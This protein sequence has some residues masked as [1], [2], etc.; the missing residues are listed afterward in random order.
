[1]R[2]SP[3]QHG[4]LDLDSLH[5]GLPHLKNAPH[6]QEQRRYRCAR[7]EVVLHP[8][9][10]RAEDTRIGRR[11]VPQERTYMRARIFGQSENSGTDVDQ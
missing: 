8:P 10:A 11:Q 9:R 1:M 4:V 5:P 3:E 2:A 7:P 6:L